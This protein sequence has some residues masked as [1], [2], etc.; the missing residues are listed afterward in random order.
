[1][2][3][4]Y[5]L[6]LTIPYVN[7]TPH[8]G[9]ALECIQGDVMARYQR[10]CGKD[11]FF[12]SGTDENSLKNVQAAE[13]AG[14]S[15]QDFVKLHAA[16]F[17]KLK[18]TLN[19]T[20]DDFIR[21]TEDRHSKG[22]QSLWNACAQDI[23]KKKY[24]GLYCVG[25]EAFYDVDELDN[26][27]C[28]EHKTPLEQVDEENYFFALSKYQKQIEE[29]LKENLI[30]IIPESRKNEMLAFVQRGLQDFS[31]SRS[32]E[33]AHGWG[34]AVP[35]DDTQIMYVWFD[36]LSNYINGLNFGG[37]KKLYEQFWLQ[38]D[39]EK[40]EVVHILGKGVA[41]FHL[42]YWIGM[43]LSAKISLPTAEFIH[44]YITVNGEKMS[45]SIGNVV[46]PQAVISKYGK[47]ASRYYFLAAIS[48]Y[49]DGDYSEERFE[50]IYTSHLVNGIGNL[51]S[52]ILTMVEKYSD[53][54]VPAVAP[55]VFDT[56]GFW[57]KYHESMN[58]FAFHEI[59]QLIQSLVSACDV[60]IN[61]TKPWD[62]FAHGESI[63]NLLY[64]LTETL[65][66]IALSIVPILPE[67]ANGI[68]VRLGSDIR[69]LKE[70]SVEQEWGR[71]DP[72]TKVVKGDILFARIKK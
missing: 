68:L 25:C 8:I 10:F 45:K 38:S 13:K 42:L 18:D 27:K 32:T 21:T 66:H 33:R 60:T 51:T 31:I 63:S 2:K 29:A 36:A 59:I 41:K 57:E 16:E 15:V 72:G 46:A 24:S 6:S 11:V 58:N 26:G 3:D 22:A 40:R 55:D 62:K 64:Q 23:Y 48:S 53:S 7:A 61:E 30:R 69:A 37:D 9:Y 35:G 39:Q 20:W 56:K 44:G 17:Y 67:T 34:V 65:R 52:R 12:L 5:F 71:I 47:E 54:K 49:Q 70:L 1:M 14:M 50:E 19:L 4:K 43:L 28:P